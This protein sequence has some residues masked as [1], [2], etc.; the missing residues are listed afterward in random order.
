VEQL[1]LCATTIEPTAHAPPEKPQQWK[2]RALQRESSPRL[3]QLEKKPMQQPR[4]STA[5][6]K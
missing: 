5:Q 1:S 3:P 6:N 2:P 4:P